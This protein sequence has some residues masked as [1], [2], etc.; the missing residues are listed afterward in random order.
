[1]KRILH[2]ILISC[3]CLS[4]AAQKN[5][6]KWMDK[7]KR[8]VF[9]ITTYGKDGNKLATNTGFFISETGEGVTAYD[10]FKGASKATV[11]DFEGKTFPVKNIQG[12]DELYDAVKFQVEVPKKT[13]FLP[14]A[15][16]PVANGTNAFLLLYS[17]GKNATFKSGAITE[18]SKLKD[19]FKY[20]KMA[21]PLEADE[22]NAPLLTPDGE[23]FGLAQA[24]AGGK[25]D[26]C[27]GLSAGYVASL[28]IGSA[29]YLSSAY[30]NIDLP[31][32]WPKE[33]DQ[34]TVALYLI[35][36]AQDVKARLETVNDFIATFPDAPDGYLNRSDLYA[37]N[38][39]ALAGS[40][41]EEADYLQKALDDVKT[42]SKYSD[43]KGDL[44]YNQ[45]K[46]IYNVASA[47]STLTDPAWT[48]AAAMEAL[49]KAIEA[50]NLPAYHQLKADI[51]FN[52]GEFEQAFNEYMIVNDSDIASASSY[53][54][55]A[56]AKER[57]TGFNIGDVIS[58]LDKAVEKC[59]A[60]MNAEAAAYVLERIDWRLRL[61]QYAEAV[62]DYDLYYTLV[63]GQVLPNFFYLREQ[64]KFRAGDL[65]G[66]LKDIQAAI[67]ASPDT[68]DFYA[69]EA[70]VYV[71]QQK[72]E[73][74]LK[75]IEK[76]IAIAPDFGACYRLRGVCYVR[77]EKKAEACEAFNKA[78]ELGDPLAEKLIKEHCK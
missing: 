17:T 28:A 27:Y 29:D 56:K 14:I 45:A 47:D 31:K 53:Y 67:Q 69:E 23:V 13:A 7:A 10:I 61:A 59:G 64:A 15:A 40:P 57:I 16:D 71:R 3:L 52:K 24:D 35:G 55:A 75:S 4:A 38:R 26:V 42:A 37:Y 73:D 32:G 33:L 70:S 77:L 5:A 60:T 6:P 54:L 25:K 78:K 22:L 18:V 65:E 68:P 34:A 30:R 12:A 62:A 76:A 44:W 46:L 2:L 50:D 8:A 21:I 51:L 41:A 20:Y 19:P 66:A 48:I 39:A 58:L 49:D 1:M 9:T 63:G 72:Y 43:K 11:T 74:A 36:G